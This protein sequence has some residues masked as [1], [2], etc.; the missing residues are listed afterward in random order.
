MKSAL[1]LA[2]AALLCLGAAKP[3]PREA[4]FL[5]GAQLNPDAKVRYFDE[6]GVA[7]SFD[8]F[9]GIVGKGRGF[10]Y[11][12]NGRISADF[13]LEPPKA[14]LPAAVRAAGSYGLHRG[15]EFPAFSLRSVAGAR[16]SNANLRGKLTLVNFFFADCVP[17]IAEIPVMNAY[18]ATHP[19]VQVMASTFDDM[20]AA[21]AF[22][23]Q[24]KLQWQVLAD[25]Q[26]LA[27][28]AGVSAYPTFALV[29][30]DGKV[31][32]IAHSAAIA[33]K[34]SKIDLASLSSWVSK[35]ANGELAR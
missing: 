20:A 35:N 1:A 22:V 2:F 21:K 33:T 16:V 4:K 11:E 32:A 13:K 30:P 9:M 8:K 7:I 19:E 18:Q 15:D 10:G 14:S 23:A 28:A 17:C 34:G 12:H 6:K 31:R 27:S 29:G 24:R 5:A 26:A 25:G 3:D